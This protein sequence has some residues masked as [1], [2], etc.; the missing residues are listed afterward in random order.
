MRPPNPNKQ[1]QVH[2][3][4]GGNAGNNIDFEFK[5]RSRSESLNYKSKHT[6]SETNAISTTE[7]LRS[8]GVIEAASPAPASRS[9]SPLFFFTPE[10]EM[11]SQGISKRKRDVDE[12]DGNGD[13]VMKPIEWKRARTGEVLEVIDLTQ[14]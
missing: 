9:A 12:T 6:F 2:R 5:Y 8:L 14:D 3:R 11:R 7:L 4:I 10:P 13:L 1:R